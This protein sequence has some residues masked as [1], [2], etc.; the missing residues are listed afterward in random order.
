MIRLS[1]Q[2]TS[3]HVRDARRLEP[4]LTHEVICSQHLCYARSFFSPLLPH[5]PNASIAFSW[6]RLSHDEVLQ[7]AP[8]L[9]FRLKKLSGAQNRT[10]FMIDFRL[11]RD[12]YVVACWIEEGTLTH[13]AEAVVD[14]YAV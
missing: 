8:R 13:K 10:H 12:E 6:S 1:Y 9:E 2:T 14:P 4:V 5:D 11:P 7:P 3:H